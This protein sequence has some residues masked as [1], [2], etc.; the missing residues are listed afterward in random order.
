MAEAVGK[1]KK[2]STG[3]GIGKIVPDL[4]NVPGINM[5][6]LKEFAKGRL[7]LEGIHYVR[8]TISSFDF[9]TLKL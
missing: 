6:A 5:D 4:P 2:R 7:L 8:Y 9:L 1:R 3:C